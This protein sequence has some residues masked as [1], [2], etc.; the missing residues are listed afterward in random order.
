MDHAGSRRAPGKLT[1]ERRWCAQALAGNVA[2]THRRANSFL[3]GRAGM[4]PS[5]PRKS[6]LAFGV[7]LAIG[8]SNAA[9]GAC[10]RSQQFG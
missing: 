6:A 9:G 8:V 2:L 10:L 7:D 5:R 3:Q 1:L 4:A